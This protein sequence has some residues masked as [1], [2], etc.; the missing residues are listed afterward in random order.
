MHENIH[1]NIITFRMGYSSSSLTAGWRSSCDGK[2]AVIRAVIISCSP[3]PWLWWHGSQPPVALWP[4]GE[5]HLWRH[6]VSI[7]CSVTLWCCSS[8][9]QHMLWPDRDLRHPCKLPAILP[10]PLLWQPQTRCIQ[11]QTS[12]QMTFTR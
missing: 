2:T 9:G 8:G 7:N 1:I 4:L 6:S 11:S 3:G 12:G 5:K 10:P